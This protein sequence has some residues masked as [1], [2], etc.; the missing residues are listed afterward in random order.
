MTNI[1]DKEKWEKDRTFSAKPGQQISED[2]YDEMFNCMP[3][4][5]LSAEAEEKAD[6]IGLYVSAGFM[7]GE[8]HSSDNHGSLF[9]A[10]G[11]SGGNYHYLGLAHK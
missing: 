10:F 11:K 2:I 8:P 4:K 9:M 7:M 1:Y 5:H 6:S 3:P